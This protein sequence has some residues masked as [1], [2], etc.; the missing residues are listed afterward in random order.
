MRFNKG[1]TI[2]RF[3]NSREIESIEKRFY[4][5]SQPIAD[6]YVMAKRMIEAGC[7]P[8]AVRSVI[9]RNERVIVNCLVE[10]SRAM[11]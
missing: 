1:M 9:L 2:K 8:S 7:K 3:C 10:L 6:K 5:T 4:N 11:K